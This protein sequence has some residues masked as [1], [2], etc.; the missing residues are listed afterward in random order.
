MTALSSHD[1]RSRD[2]ARIHYDLR[3]SGT[4]TLVF[5]H[6]WLGS[7]RWWDDTT[8]DL[9]RDHGTIAIDLAGHGRSSER[10]VYTVERYADDIVAVI[11]A[12][13]ALHET[14]AAK[15]IVL[16]GHSMSGGHVLAAA[17]RV[18]DL[19]G[20]VLVDTLKDLEARQPPEL[21]DRMLGL[22]RGDFETAV[23]Q[24]LPQFLYSPS[25]PPNVIERLATEFLRVSGEGAA[26]RLEPY[27][28][29]DPREDARGLMVPVR[30]IDGDVHPAAVETN[31]RYLRDFARREIAGCGH[32]PMLEQP[33]RF[34]ALLRESLSD[35]ESR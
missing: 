2:G 9:S 22:Y 12:R 18:S 19:R 35:L 3:G 8:A 20:V 11:E 14:S 27:L 17:K 15:H 31:R 34:I 5:V 6:G 28:H 33:E 7:A 10:D 16:V 13:A 1:T 4:F 21:I 23:R 24:V 25:T 29:H 30:A 26:A 32:Y